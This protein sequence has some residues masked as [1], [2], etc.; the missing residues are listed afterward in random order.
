MYKIT[1]YLV[2]FGTFLTPPAIGV[3]GDVHNKLKQ[4]SRENMLSIR[5]YDT[6]ACSEQ[7]ARNGNVCGIHPA[8]SFRC[9][10]C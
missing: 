1:V 9:T 3:V 5:L 7:R 6:L 2:C 10:V 8:R 4:K